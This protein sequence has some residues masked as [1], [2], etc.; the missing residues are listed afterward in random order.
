[1]TSDATA[2]LG[3]NRQGRATRRALID[4]GWTRADG[5]RLI[6]LFAALRPGRVAARAGRSAGAFRH[7]FPSID[8]LVE[9]MMEEMISAAEGVGSDTLTASEVPGGPDLVSHV[10]SDATGVSEPEHPLGPAER[11]IGLVLSRTEHDE[12]A[13]DVARREMEGRLDGLA[14]A[15]LEMMGRFGREPIPPL[16]LDQILAASVGTTFGM[17]VRRAATP[18][19][20][21]DSLMADAWMA[22]T[23][24]FTRDAT[25]THSTSD[26][27]VELRPGRDV[28]G[29]RPSAIVDRPEMRAVLELFGREWEQGSLSEVADGV[30]TVGGGRE[31]PVRQRATRRGRELR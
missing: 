31:V 17:L 7:H 30:G 26:S 8:V 9:A 25:S 5:L 20:V 19:S 6:D 28:A 16:S 15:S 29:D 13:L 10:R 3:S 22:E 27:L 18:S 4:A 21:P 2:S 12:M 14:V 1:M 24:A 11:R 23:L